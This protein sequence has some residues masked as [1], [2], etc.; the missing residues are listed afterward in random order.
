M[1]VQLILFRV[2]KS[3]GLFCLNWVYDFID[4]D[5]DG[6]IEKKEIKNLNSRIKKWLQ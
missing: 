2:L 3:V 5:K 6:V 4:E 1:N